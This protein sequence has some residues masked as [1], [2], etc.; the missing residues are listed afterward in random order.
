MQL[1]LPDHER[2]SQSVADFI[3]GRASTTVGS[4]SCQ[5]R[6]SVK[7]E[8]E[9]K[10]RRHVSNV[11]EKIEIFRLHKV[12]CTGVFEGA[13]SKGS[14]SFGKAEFQKKHRLNGKNSKEQR[15]I[16]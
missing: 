12:F 11:L 6:S 2:I 16:G 10:R 4:L 8:R 14:A 15:F 7:D 9:E 1:Q 5:N 13:I 3:Q